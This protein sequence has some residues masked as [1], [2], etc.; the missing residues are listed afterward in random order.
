MSILDNVK[1]IKENIA[2]SAQKA[3]KKPEDIILVAAAKMYPSESVREAIS[4]G[5]DAVGENR[6]QEMAEKL[7]QG[8]YE[9]APLHFIG[10][11]QKNKVKNVVGKADLIESIDSVELLRLV[12]K[13]AK[14]LGI[15]Q[16]LL[17]EVNIASE[18]SKSGFSQNEL[19]DVL[20]EASQL[21]SIKVEGLMAIPPISTSPGGNREHFAS[22]FKLFVDIREKKYDNVT[23]GSLSMGMSGDYSDAI[24]EGANMVRI[25]TGIFGSRNYSIG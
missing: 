19:Y 8:A 1:I 23:M 9:G 7:S 12:D 13:R 16:R 25:G 24:S 2:A 15:V 4:A 22:M 20:E 5:V 14:S 3:G 17:L 10:H 11:L 21:E 18:A 6:V